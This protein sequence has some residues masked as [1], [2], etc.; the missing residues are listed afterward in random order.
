MFIW[1]FFDL[2]FDGIVGVGYF[3]VFFGG[4]VN[5]ER[6]RVE[7]VVYLIGFGID[8][9]RWLVVFFGDGEVFV[10]EGGFCGIKSN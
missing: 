6:F 1:D 10:L 7:L 9:D 5:L 2:Y 3:C 4:V 8:V